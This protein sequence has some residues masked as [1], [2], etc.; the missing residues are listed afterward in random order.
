MDLYDVIGLLSIIVG[1]AVSNAGGIGGGGLFVPIL[2]LILKFDTHEAIPISKLMILSGAITAFIL[3]FKL[4]HPSR[5]TI[6]IDYN[7]AI[8]IVPMLLFGTVVGVTLN[9]I[10]SDFMIILMLT[11]VLLINT[12]T[13]LKQAISIFRKENYEKLL[14]NSEKSEKFESFNCRNSLNKADESHVSQVGNPSD[15]N[16]IDHEHEPELES[17]GELQSKENLVKIELEKDQHVFQWNKLKYLV[18]SYTLMLFLTFMLGS[19]YFKSVVGI[20]KCSLEYWLVYSINFP[21]AVLITFY[22]ARAIRNENKY[23]LNI[24]FPYDH[25]DIIWNTNLIIKYPIYGFF[26]GILAG[27]VGIGGG[28]VLGPLF[29]GLG[30]NPIISTVTSNFLVIFTS[31]ST[32]LQFILSGMLNFTYGGIC[33]IF[34]ILGSLIGTLTIHYI[35]LVFKRQSIFVFILAFVLISSTILLPLNSITQIFD[36]IHNFEELITFNSFC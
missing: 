4:K 7:I 14:K 26:S 16:L 18:L 6:S 30:I 21:V 32:T 34:S 3:N 19:D 23:R 10:F 27:L 17:G 28:L 31:S 29:I 12:F 5:N 22:G 36:K 9:K 35:L 11:L 2:I 13:T 25:N 33:T 24:G 1:S 20:T 15:K 8:L